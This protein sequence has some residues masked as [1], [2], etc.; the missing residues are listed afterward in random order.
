MAKVPSEHFTYLS[1]DI[2]QD[3]PWSLNLRCMVLSQC[4]K[5]RPT[6]FLHTHSAQIRLTSERLCKQ[7]SI[8]LRSIRKTLALIRPNPDRSIQIQVQYSLFNFVCLTRGKHILFTINFLLL[9]CQF[10]PNKRLNNLNYHKV[11]F[12][13][14][15]RTNTHISLSFTATGVCIVHNLIKVH[16]YNITK[17]YVICVYFM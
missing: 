14:S 2:L 5:N 10:R 9:N 8:G 4:N 1:A 17:Y 13:L 6:D 16:V 3:R 11:Q 12:H 15:A 7:S